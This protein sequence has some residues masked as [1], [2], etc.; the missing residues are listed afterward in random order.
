MSD[1]VQ[2]LVNYVKEVHG[3]DV[4]PH[5]IAILE[6]MNRNT[7]IQKQVQFINKKLGIQLLEWQIRYIFTDEMVNK[8][9]GRRNGKELAYVLRTLLTDGEPLKLYKSDSS[10]VDYIRDRPYSK[11][12]TDRV[13]GIYTK[14]NV[15]D[16]PLK[17]RK[18]Y[19][20]REEYE[21][22]KK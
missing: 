13:Q 18:V 11:W 12:Y 15:P 20:C 2:D 5:Q 19:F 6:A 1:D 8:Q 16:S 9:L 3:V 17:L 22:E 4:P 14:L 7:Q 21:N 10:R